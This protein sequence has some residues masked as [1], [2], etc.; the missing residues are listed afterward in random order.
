MR[1]QR[2]ITAEHI[3]QNPFIFNILWSDPIEDDD[4][5]GGKN[6]GLHP[7]PRGK[8]AVKFGWDVTYDFCQRN[9]INL[10]IRSH[11]A[12]KGGYGFDCMHEMMLMRVFTARDYDKY[13]NDGAIL[14]IEEIHDGILKVRPQVLRS[15]NKDEESD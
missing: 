5:M 11:Q 4:P 8:A 14:L 9:N 7:S 15:L 6:F 12:K 2:P 10:V 3:L 1:L 13:K